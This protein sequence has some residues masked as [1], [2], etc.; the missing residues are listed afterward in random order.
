MGPGRKL[1]TF[2]KEMIE[3]LIKL[4]SPTTRQFWKIPVLFEDE[5]FLALDKPARLP[6]SPERDDPQTPSLMT[7][8]HR[9]IQRGAAWAAER[10]LGYLTKTYR[11]DC[12][13][14]GVLVLAK[15]KG[16][17]VAM[18]N[19]FG[20]EEPLLRCLALIQGAPRQDAFSVSAKLAPHPLQPG[21]MRVDERGGKRSRTDFRVLERFRTHALLH[22]FPLT[23]RRHQI[24]AHLRHAGFP[25]VGDDSYGGA[26]LLLS[27]LKGAYRLKRD[28][29]ER[30]LIGRTALHV[31]QLSFNQPVTGASV[32]IQAPWPKDL[33][34]AV[35]Y[36]RRYAGGEAG[37]VEEDFP[38]SNS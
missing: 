29:E 6:A 10:E 32:T 1:S 14:S 12:E 19:L 37:G 13:T 34:V 5:H 33:T 36:L 27:R 9:D 38:S 18:A 23:H 7:L 21:R 24:R 8:L 2:A 3:P 35:K 20:S 26:P 17:L 16:A 28:K 30:P 25:M 15:N 11:L 4:S 22:C 31:E